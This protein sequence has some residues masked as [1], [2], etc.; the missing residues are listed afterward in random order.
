L[1][2]NFAVGLLAGSFVINFPFLTQSIVDV[3]IQ[4]QDINFIYLVLLAQ[5]MLFWEEWEL[6]LSAGFSSSFYKN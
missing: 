2:F 3:G 6:K 4:N 1:S 5:V